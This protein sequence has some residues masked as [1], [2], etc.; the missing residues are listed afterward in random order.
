MKYSFIKA[1]LANFS[2]WLPDY[3]LANHNHNLIVE[4]NFS[5]SVSSQLLSK[6]Q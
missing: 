1:I 4:H 3:D 5:Q 6:A 2:I